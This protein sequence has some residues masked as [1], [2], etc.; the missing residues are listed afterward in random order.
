MCAGVFQLSAPAV[1]VL[2][3]GWRDA[4]GVVVA[5]APVVE[6]VDPHQ[7]GQLQVVEA[8]PVAEVAD[9]FGLVEP[10]KWPASARTRLP[11]SP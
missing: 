1:E 2:G 7:S 10:R 8:P 5:D 9:Q 6:P 3:F 4:A 11:R